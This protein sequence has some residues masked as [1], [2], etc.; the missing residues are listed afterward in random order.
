[1]TLDFAARYFLMPNKLKYSQDKEEK[2]IDRMLFDFCCGNLKKHEIEPILQ[3]YNALLMYLD[4]IAKKH[5]KSMYD[6]DVLEAYWIGNELLD[7]ISSEDMKKHFEVEMTKAKAPKKIIKD[8]TNSIP[9]NCHPHHSFHVLHIQAIT[10]DPN[11]MYGN[12]RMC[13]IDHGKV[14]QIKQN[15]LILQKDKNEKTI[16]YDPEFLKN[17]KVGDVIAYHWDF[18]IDKITKKQSTHLDHYTEKHK[19]VMN[20]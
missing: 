11:L 14:K 1:M 8:V 7:S 5:N 15:L 10:K 19:K 16:G 12:F 3:K 20:V 6:E 9:E 17:V 4:L 2:D 13:K 18:A